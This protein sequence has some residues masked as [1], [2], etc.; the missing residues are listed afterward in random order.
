[1]SMTDGVRVEYQ[2]ET[3]WVGKFW[4]TGSG[5]AR[6]L[7]VV[8]TESDGSGHWVEWPIS[9]DSDWYGIVAAFDRVIQMAREERGKAEPATRC[10]A[11]AV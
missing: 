11:C 1:M 6:W 2:G 5:D 9:A 4:G 10:E 7:S 3:I 8:L